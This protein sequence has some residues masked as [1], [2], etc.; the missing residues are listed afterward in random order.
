MIVLPAPAS[1]ASRKRTRASFEEVVVDRLQL[2]GQRIDAGDGQA[3]VGVELVG[4]PER[5]GL[6]AEPQQLSVAVVGERNRGS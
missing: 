5:V 4:D 2:V 3:E 6:K 1:S